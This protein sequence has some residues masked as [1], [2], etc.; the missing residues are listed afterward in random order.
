MFY[1][2][3]IKIETV[4]K[5][6]NKFLNKYTYININKLTKPVTKENILLSYYNFTYNTTK[7]INNSKQC[8]Y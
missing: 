8:T 4:N 7:N 1:L 6:I 5:I 2:F 3:N